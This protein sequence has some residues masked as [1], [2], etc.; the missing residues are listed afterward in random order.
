[1]SEVRDTVI[2]DEH[3]QEENG[4]HL[5]QLNTQCYTDPV[6]CTAISSLVDVFGLVGFGTS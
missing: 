4:A 1:M 3:R 2:L 5:A 6:G